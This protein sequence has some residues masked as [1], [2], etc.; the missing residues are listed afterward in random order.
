MWPFHSVSQDRDKDLREAREAAERNAKLAMHHAQQSN[1]FGAGFVGT[2]PAKPK[3]ATDLPLTRVSDLAGYLGRVHE[4]L[5]FA[6]ILFMNEK[7]T[8]RS[9]AIA[10]K[11]Q[12]AADK[13]GSV[14]MDL[15]T[16]I[17]EARE[18]EALAVIQQQAEAITRDFEDTVTS[19]WSPRSQWTT[20]EMEV[21]RRAN[22]ATEPLEPN[23]INPVPEPMTMNRINPVGDADTVNC[24][25]CDGIGVIGVHVCLTCGGDGMSPARPPAA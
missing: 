25:S 12:D 7:E 21:Y 3:L 5:A 22:V 6:A 9:N 19:A 14:Q 24:T 8:A 11:F 17:A 4:L 10:Q 13:A 18:V 23:R 15:L 2:V 16:I 20:E 1:T